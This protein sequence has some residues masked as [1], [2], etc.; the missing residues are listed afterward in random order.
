MHARRRISKVVRQLFGDRFHGRL[1][2][3]V[4]GVAGRVGDALFGAGD[5]DGGSGGAA[6][7]FQEVGDAMEDAV[8]TGAGPVFNGTSTTPGS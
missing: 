3:V 6:H 8:P 1:A 2:G 5:D 7:N 4:G